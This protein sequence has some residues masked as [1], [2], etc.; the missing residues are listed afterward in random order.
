MS[1]LAT[2][3]HNIPPASVAQRLRGR[4]QWAAYQALAAAAGEWVEAAVLAAQVYKEPHYSWERTSSLLSV[5]HRLRKKGVP[6]QTYYVPS[7]YATRYRLPLDWQRQ[8]GNDDAG[9]RD[10]R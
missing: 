3:T 4:A 1:D 2:T 10:G 5:I 8:Q 9:G 7:T 6:I